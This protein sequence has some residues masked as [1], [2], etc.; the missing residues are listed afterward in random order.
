MILNYASSFFWLFMEGDELYVP[1]SNRFI[2]W[3]ECV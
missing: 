1:L 3:G 2:R